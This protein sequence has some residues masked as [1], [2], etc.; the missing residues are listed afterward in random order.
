MAG[1]FDILEGYVERIAALLHEHMDLVDSIERY[2]SFMYSLDEVKEAHI[3]ALKDQLEN[4][5]QLR[6]SIIESMGRAVEAARGARGEG[7]EALSDLYALI[8][9]YVEAGV[10]REISVLKKASLFLDMKSHLESSERAREEASRIVEEL[11]GL[12]S[13]G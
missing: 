1:N 2:V 12:G 4:L 5:S 13:E 8:S 6:S 10:A 11:E 7:E 9:Y 3:S